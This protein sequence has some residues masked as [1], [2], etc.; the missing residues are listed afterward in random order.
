MIY[1]AQF[2]EVFCYPFSF[3]FSVW[4]SAFHQH[5]DVWHHGAGAVDPGAV[6]ERGAGALPLHHPD[7]PDPWETQGM[8]GIQ[9]TQ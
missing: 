4:Y 6:W 7:L 8:A 3:P 5:P 9:V 2:S 1:Q